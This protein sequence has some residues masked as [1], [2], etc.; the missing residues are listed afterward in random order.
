MEEWVKLIGNW[1]FPLALCIY[2][3]TRQE[4]KLGA[5]TKAIASLNQTLAV[6]ADRVMRP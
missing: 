4:A 6:I 5:L 1:G 2:L 3:L